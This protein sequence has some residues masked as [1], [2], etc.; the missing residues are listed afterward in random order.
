MRNNQW[1]RE[2]ER[3]QRVKNQN[4]GLKDTV[5]L[6]VCG[7]IGD[8]QE[9]TLGPPP[10]CKGRRGLLSVALMCGSPPTTGSPRGVC[11]PSGSASS[12]FS[13]Q[14]LGFFLSFGPSGHRPPGSGGETSGQMCCPGSLPHP[15]L[16]CLFSRQGSWSFTA[17]SAVTAEDRLLK[18]RQ[19]GKGTAGAPDSG[20]PTVS[21][22]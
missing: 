3:C 1:T 14:Q 2:K 12:D 16:P 17:L 6:D 7:Q 11:Q 21:R 22:G 10:Q 8:H 13:E 9:M 19:G 15:P 20:V 18:G 5:T 4:T